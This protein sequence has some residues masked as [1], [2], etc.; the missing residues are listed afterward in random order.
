MRGFFIASI[1]EKN[2][3]IDNLVNTGSGL[4]REDVM[5]ISSD[6]EHYISLSEYKEQSG[7]NNAEENTPNHSRQILD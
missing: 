2:W 6:D 4:K 3:I 5:I 1:P 7:N